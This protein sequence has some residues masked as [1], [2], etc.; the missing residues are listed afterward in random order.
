MQSTPSVSSPCSPEYSDCLP[1]IHTNSLLAVQAL[2]LRT[3]NIL[4]PFDCCSNGFNWPHFTPCYK[5]TPI[6]I[7]TSKTVRRQIAMGFYNIEG[8]K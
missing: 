5:D 8:M 2:N 1:I 3:E 4:L 7:Y 6:W